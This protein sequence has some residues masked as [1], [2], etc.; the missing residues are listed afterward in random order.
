MTDPAEP[1]DRTVRRRQR[2]RAAARFAAHAF[3]KDAV[4]AD[5]AGRLADLGADFARVLDLGGHDG[6]L[7]AA[8]GAAWTVVVE[9]SPAM[10]RR[11][12]GRAVVVAD[13]DRL[14]FGDA[15]FD[16]IVSALS[17]HSVND[18][19]GALIQARRALRPGGVFL[20]SLF[21]G[22]SLGG[23]RRDLIEAEAALTGRAAA[24]VM[25][26]VDRFSSVA[27]VSRVW[28]PAVWMRQMWVCLL[29][30]R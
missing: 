5:L 11:A 25:P 20:A 17:L 14:P 16:L 29:P 27:L 21:A 8:F 28:S 18:L 10:A 22:S 9:P 7:A 2:D 26:M 30:G 23:V 3:L 13:E 6:R 1:F 24:R 12:A 19:P 4:A 15:S